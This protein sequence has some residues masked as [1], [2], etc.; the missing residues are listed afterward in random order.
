MKKFV[1]L[2]L[3]ALSGLIIHA[4]TKNEI[5]QDVAWGKVKE[6]IKEDLDSVNVFVSYSV[7]T[8]NKTISTWNGNEISPAFESWF[9]L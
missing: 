3:L 2:Y 9:F 6:I 5:T 8:P 7:L 1:V 4:Q